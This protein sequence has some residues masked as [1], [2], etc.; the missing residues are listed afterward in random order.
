MMTNWEARTVSVA[1]RVHV[2][3]VSNTDTNTCRTRFRPCRRSEAGLVGSGYGPDT[4]NTS[5]VGLK[6]N[7]IQII[8]ISSPSLPSSSISLLSSSILDLSLS[9]LSRS[10]SAATAT[11]TKV[12]F[13]FRVFDII[14]FFYRSNSSGVVGSSSP[15]D[16]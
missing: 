1:H 5:Q 11:T 16:R 7:Q 3:H 8:Y 12:N 10:V 9:P 14:L 4:A 2:G 6:K 15:R 13:K